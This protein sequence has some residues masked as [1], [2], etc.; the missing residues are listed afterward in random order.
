MRYVGSF[1]YLPLNTADGDSMRWLQLRGGGKR[2]VTWVSYERDVESVGCHLH[3]RVVAVI[4]HYSCLQACVD[5]R[6]SFFLQ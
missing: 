5:T 3:T 2:W 4:F 1:E 6:S